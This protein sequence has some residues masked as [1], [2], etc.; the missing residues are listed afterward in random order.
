MILRKVSYKMASIKVMECYIVNTDNNNEIMHTYFYKSYD[1]LYIQC[2]KEECKEC[3]GDGTHGT[4]DTNFDVDCEECNAT[5]Y[6]WIN[7]GLFIYPVVNDS[8]EFVEIY[9]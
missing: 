5:G 4:W 7:D 1:G 9:Y 2:E 3:D 6:K 8:I